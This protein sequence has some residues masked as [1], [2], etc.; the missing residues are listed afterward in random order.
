MARAS[1]KVEITMTAQEAQAVQ[2]WMRLRAVGPQGFEKDVR[3]TGAAGAKAGTQIKQGMLGAGAAI[4]VLRRDVLAMA[5][6][7]LGVQQAMSAIRN[8]ADAIRKLQQTA[9]QSQTAFGKQLQRTFNALPEGSD[10][11][12]SGLKD[13]V[14]SERQIK[15]RVS[16]ID[17]L[18][19]IQGVFAAKGPLVS[20]KESVD[21]SQ[22]VSEIFP[23]VADKP[24]DILAINKAALSIKKTFPEAGSIKDILSS[25]NEGFQQSNVTDPAKFAATIVALTGQL[26][27]ITDDPNDSLEKFLAF[28]SALTQ[29]SLED[30]GK[31]TATA[32]VNLLT[33]MRANALGTGAI[34]SD[35]G[36]FAGKDAFK[37][38]GRSRETEAVRQ[39]LVGVLDASLGDVERIIKESPS[40]GELVRPPG[41][42]GERRMRPG[43][44]QVLGGDTETLFD[45][46]FEASL[47]NISTITEGGDVLQAR[48]E[49]VR[50]EP[51][52]A[53]AELS[54]IAANRLKVAE[55]LSETG[56]AAAI[57]EE[58]KDLAI[59]SGSSSFMAS[60]RGFE[61]SVMGRNDT[62]VESLQRRVRLLEAGIERAQT[63][64][65]GSMLTEP[66]FTPGEGPTMNERVPFAHLFEPMRQ[67][68]ESQNKA[69]EE[70]KLMRLDLIAHIK[71]LTEAT[72]NK[73]LKII[74]ENE[75]GIPEPARANVPQ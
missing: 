71:L 57:S 29:V 36:V 46:L 20:A 72:Q 38:P 7:F 70:A 64:M 4:K 75:N 42:G 6:G 58:I 28:G 13:A 54:G 51:V 9:G 48:R 56:A 24:A 49:R 73:P 33:T 17:Q 35:Q 66:N 74:V 47:K 5:T 19:A 39:R 41:M 14:L 37:D 32:M 60:F 25:L 55:I 12:L 52:M 10:I 61:T 30:T 69:N 53:A 16:P 2:A 8:E 31:L 21:I 50:A 43:M 34:T 62:L 40:L 15:T 22:T 65:F 3:K 1:G 67:L 63:P 59:R 26:K 68:S 44:A 23:S 27:Q 18:V 11:T 45:R